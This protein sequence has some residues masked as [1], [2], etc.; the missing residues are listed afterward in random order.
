MNFINRTPINFLVS[1][2]LVC[3]SVIFLS[4]FILD[5]NSLINQTMVMF[6][7]AIGFLILSFSGLPIIIKK[8]IPNFF[9]KLFGESELFTGILLVVIGF[10]P[11]TYLIY[12]TLLNIFTH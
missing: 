8:E 7:S 11:F 9:C 2:P 10:I 6:L 5:M 3:S 12:S 4:V 1:I